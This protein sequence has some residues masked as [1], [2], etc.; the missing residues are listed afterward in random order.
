MSA[1]IW[2]YK[3]KQRKFG[4]K[5]TWKNLPLLIHVWS[6]IPTLVLVPCLNRL[7][8]G[9]MLRLIFEVLL[10]NV[11]FEPIYHQPIIKLSFASC[12]MIFS[13]LFTW[14]PKSFTHVFTLFN[15]YPPHFLSLV[16]IS[17]SQPQTPAN[18]F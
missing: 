4:V 1:H 5:N 12:S 15:F 9:E 6:A 17:S 11:R 14:I 7:S 13:I 8:F 18:E 10:R 3:T 2:N 16:T